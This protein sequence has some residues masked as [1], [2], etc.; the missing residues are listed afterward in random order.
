SMEKKFLPDF[1]QDIETKFNGDIDRFTDDLFDRSLF[2]NIDK[3]NKWMKNPVV[4]YEDDPAVRIIKQVE[5]KKGE[6][7]KKLREFENSVKNQQA[8]YYNYAANSITGAYYPNADKTVRI[9]YGQV[10]PL[11]TPEGVKHSY[12]TT[13]EGVIKKE[14]ST[15]RDFFLP[16]TMKDLWNKKD[17]GR[18]AVN[19][20]V[21]VSFIVNADVT[22]GNSGSPMMNAK[23]ELIGLLY[24]CNWESMT[25]DYN[26][27]KELHRAI[28]LDVRYLL[29]VVEKYG[30]SKHL[31]DEILG[32]K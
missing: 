28:C 3:I 23:G 18:Y 16:Q 21:P 14:N 4:K 1:Y 5:A 10:A 24:D 20:D 25:R 17:F 27:D 7:S 26:F 8:A 15:N 30:N 12:Q 31:V 9:T 32:S 29:F 22:G 2:A 11:T 13:L 19:G 6:I